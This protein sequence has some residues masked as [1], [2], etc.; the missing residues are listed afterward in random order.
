MN[1]QDKW[2]G[3][4]YEM[5]DCKNID[6]ITKL[7]G[8]E[9]CDVD[10]D[11]CIINDSDSYL[12][13]EEDFIEKSSTFV[14]IADKLTIKNYKENIQYIT[15]KFNKITLENNDNL[16]YNEVIYHNNIKGL[17]TDSLNISIQILYKFEQ[18][19][20]INKIMNIYIL[21]FLANHTEHDDNIF[22]FKID[23]IDRY[24]SF[25]LDFKEL[26]E[27]DLKPIYNW[28]VNQSDYKDSYK[29]KLNI[30]RELIVKNNCYNLSADDLFSCDS[31][32]NRLAAGEVN[33]YFIQINILKADFIKM[34]STKTDIF[35]ILHLKILTWL[36]AIGVII[37]DEIK[38][39]EES[40][41]VGLYELLFCSSSEKAQIISM[42]LLISLI[43]IALMFWREYKNLVEE[44]NAIE[45]YY[46]DRIHLTTKDYESY[47]LKPKINE[48][49]ILFF[50]AS[51]ISLF[52]RLMFSI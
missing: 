4:S 44:Y 18:S 43:I 49:Y 2:N 7:F 31:I 9:I 19:D 47:T 17:S 27:L 29:A 20:T 36:G 32:Y 52:I 34:E 28:I 39:F 37:F 21:L 5:Y 8:S 22:K 23:L 15:D 45:K 24:Y 41:S 35:R 38:S 12:F 33:E 16:I 30:V 11:N 13:K 48:I 26:I 10:G 1:S 40:D 25:N 46:V 50:I 3:H 6:L 42:M 51:F 14:K